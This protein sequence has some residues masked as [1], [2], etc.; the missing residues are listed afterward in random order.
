V[1]HRRYGIKDRLLTGVPSS[2]A[3][4]VTLPALRPWF[5]FFYYRGERT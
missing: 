5:L 4:L 3:M 1:I 2:I